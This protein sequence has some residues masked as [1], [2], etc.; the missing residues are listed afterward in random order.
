MAH[1]PYSEWCMIP[2]TA[3]GHLPPPIYIPVTL[4]T[5]F[6]ARPARLVLGLQQHSLQVPHL[7]GV[8][9]LLPTS[10]RAVSLG[11][12]A[13]E[14]ELYP[15]ICKSKYNN[16]RPIFL[17]NSQLLAGL[18]MVATPWPK[19]FILS[20]CLFVCFYQLVLAQYCS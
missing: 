7:D 6:G 5:S 13:T 14:V 18:H 17:C 12:K 2:G 8:R 11:V 16:H 1:P 19:L 4:R 20:F 9:D 3:C 10:Q 15:G